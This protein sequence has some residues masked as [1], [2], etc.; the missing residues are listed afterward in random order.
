MFGTSLPTTHCL[1]FSRRIC[2]DISSHF[3]GTTNIS[4]WANGYQSVRDTNNL[5]SY[6][7]VEHGLLITFCILYKCDG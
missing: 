4:V 7:L 6:E 5:S 2:Y 1:Y 3:T